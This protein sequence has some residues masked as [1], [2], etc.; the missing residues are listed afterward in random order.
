MKWIL[1]TAALSGAFVWFWYAAVRDQGRR[2]EQEDKNV[3]PH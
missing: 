2:A 3:E 1:L